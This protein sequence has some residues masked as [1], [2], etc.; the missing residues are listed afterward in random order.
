VGW[1]LSNTM[2][3]TGKIPEIF[4]IDHGGQLTSVEWTGGLTDRSHLRRGPRTPARRDCVSPRMAG[5]FGV[6]PELFPNLCLSRSK[7]S[8]SGHRAVRL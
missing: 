1:T 7:K 3:A 2:G 8:V 6:G 4:D 5:S